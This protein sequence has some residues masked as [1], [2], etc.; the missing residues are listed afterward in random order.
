M[1]LDYS[2]KIILQ[3]RNQQKYITG[4]SN[5]YVGRDRRKYVYIV[6]VDIGCL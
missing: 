1:A 6:F 5:K 4:S 3:N 2:R